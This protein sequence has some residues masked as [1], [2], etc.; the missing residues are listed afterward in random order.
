MRAPELAPYA[1]SPLTLPSGAL[2]LASRAPGMGCPPELEI[3]NGSRMVV[4]TT[5]AARVRRGDRLGWA[6]MRLL[7]DRGSAGS[8]RPE[9]DAPFELTGSLQNLEECVARLG[10]RVQK[11]ELCVEL[12]AGVQKRMHE[13]DQALQWLLGVLH[14]T[15]ARAQAGIRMPGDGVRSEPL[16]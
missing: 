6:A 13:R 5:G 15:G 9:A 2:G 16:F 14:D 7:S 10:G 12:L 3:V 8:R 1:S 4:F 11:P